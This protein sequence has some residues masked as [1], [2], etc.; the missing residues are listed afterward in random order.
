M[1]YYIS[2]AFINVMNN[3]KREY[4]MKCP[5]SMYLLSDPLLRDIAAV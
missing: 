3:A 1:D 2:Y 4:C 5:A